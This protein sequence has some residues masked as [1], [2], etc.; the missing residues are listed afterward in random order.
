MILKWREIVLALKINC[1]NPILY[2]IYIILDLKV[3]SMSSILGL[4]IEL[5]NTWANMVSTL[6]SIGSTIVH[7]T[8]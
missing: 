4:I 8:H 2:K 3:S 7:G 6:S 1:R 5:L